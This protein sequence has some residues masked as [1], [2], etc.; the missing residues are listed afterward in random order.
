MSRDAMDDT[1]NSLCVIDLSGEIIS[2]ANKSLTINQE[3]QDSGS[4]DRR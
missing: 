4:H 3:F 2:T 1:P